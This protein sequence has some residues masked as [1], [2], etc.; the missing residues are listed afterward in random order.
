MDGVGDI[1]A[2]DFRA[3]VA[4]AGVIIR[5][6]RFAFR[7]RSPVEHLADEVHRMYR[8]HPVSLEGFADFHVEVRPPRTL[9]RWFGKQL[10]FHVDGSSSFFPLPHAQ[11]FPLL[12]WGL[13]WCVHDAVKDCLILHAAVVEKDGKAL[14]IPAPPGSGKSTLVAGLVHQGWRLLS[15][16]LAPLAL[17]G[18]SVEGLARPISLK[19]DSIDLIKG[20]V[21]EDAFSETVRDTV[22]GSVALMRPP[23]ESVLSVRRPA[24]PA[25][26]IFPK[27]TRGARPV[28]QG[29]GQGAGFALLMESAFN[30]SVLRRRGFEAL[31]DLVARCECYEIGYGSLDEGMQLVEDIHA[32]A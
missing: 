17:D 4:D 12:E 15:D 9:R 7:L 11:A 1:P 3:L 23:R 22:K 18:L 24:T 2:R 14:L 16:E 8:Y 32:A 6:G 30:F 29:L 31:A 10:E 21:G 27:F 26:V 28:S 13:N 20:L 5:F 25:A 19:N